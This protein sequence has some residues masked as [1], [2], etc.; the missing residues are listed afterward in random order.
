[1]DNDKRIDDI[2]AMLDGFTTKNGGHTIAQ[3]HVRPTVQKY[4]EKFVD[5]FERRVKR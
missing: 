4:K 5:V 1:M 3:P 2:I